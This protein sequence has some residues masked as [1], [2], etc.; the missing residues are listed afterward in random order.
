M[1]VFDFQGV[2]AFGNFIYVIG[3]YSSNQQLNS[4]E[5]YDILANQWTFIEP[6]NI[7]RSAAACTV[8]NTKLIAMGGYDGNEFLSSV[9]CYDMEKKQ[10]QISSQLTSERSG[11]AAVVSVE[12]NS[13]MN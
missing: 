9:E 6:M 4:V 7:A 13:K 3:G 8:W 2:V 11:H 1:I 5:R 10:W 12:K